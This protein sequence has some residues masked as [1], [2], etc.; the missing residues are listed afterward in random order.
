MKLE[1]YN[2][3]RE[4]KLTANTAESSTWNVE[5]MAENALSVS[6]TQ[7]S[8]VALEVGDYVML[9]GIKFSINKEYKPKQVSTLEYNYNVKFYGPEHDAERVLFLNLTDGQYVSEFILDGSPI[10]HLQRWVENM[11]RIYGKTVWSIG[12]VVVSAYKTI[13]YNN[14]NCWDALA[15]MAETFETEWWADGFVINLCR[16]ERGVRVPLGYMEGMTSLNQAENSSTVKFFTRLIPLGSTRNIDRQRYG[17][18]RLQLPNRE[19]YV[20]RNMH[21]GLFEA[22][23]SAA[24]ADIYPRYRGTV[25]SVRQEEKVGEDEKHFTVYYF[26]DNGMDFDPSQYGIDGQVKHITFQTGDLAGRDFEAN[27]YA[28]A[29][30]WEI[31]NTYPS[32]QY[33]VPGGN[34]IPRPG[35]EYIPW[36]FS[37]PTEYIRRAEKE[38]KA[39]VDDYLAKYSNDI[40]KYGGDTDAI[41]IEK[42]SVPLQLGQSVRLLSPK[43]FGAEGGRDSRMTKVVRKLDNL[44]SASIECTNQV[45][46]G[47]KKSVDSSLDQ[48]KYVVAQQQEESALDIMKSWDSR[49]FT[50]YRVLSALR[51]LNEIAL[52]ALSRL[53]NDEAAGLIT[54]LKGV[55]IGNKGRGIT[56]GINGSV[57]AVMDEIKKILSIVS[58]S[59]VSG[60][61]GSGFILKE[62]AETGDSY[63]EIDHLLVRKLAYF[64]EI[65]IKRLSYVGG[66]IILTP[67]SMKCIRVEDQGASY[68]C[69][70]EQSDDEKT[71][72]QEFQVGDQARAQTFNIKEGTSHGAS[73]NYYWRLV[74]GV[75]DDYIDLSKDDCDAKSSIPIAGDHIVQLGNRTDATRQ[76]AIILSTVGDDAPSIKQYKGINSYS[77]K[78]KEV[79]IISQALNMFQG[80]FISSSTGKSVDDMISNLQADMDLVREQTDREY[81]LWFFDYAP[82]LEN[83]PASD[84]VTDELKIMHEQ[85]MFY[86]RITGLAYRFEQVGNIWVWS[87]ITDQFTLAALEK[88]AKA[89][90]TADGKRR[91][92]VEQPR[93][94]QVYDVGDLWVNATYGLIYKN[95]QLVCKTA[96][97]AGEVFDIEHWRPASNITTAYIE[98]LG[99]QIILGVTNDTDKKIEA[100]KELAQ[101]GIKTATDIA[102]DAVRRIGDLSVDLSTLSGRMN[103]AD[104]TIVEHTTAIQATQ[105]SIA[106]LAQGKE[107]DE[108]GNITNISTSGLVTTA[109]FNSLFSERVEFDENGQIVNVKSSGI[110]TTADFS[111]MFSERADD[112][113]EGY[114]KRSYMATFITELP[115]GSF[116][117]NAIVDADL[118]RFNG[119]I[120][121]NDTFMVDKEGNLTLN[122]ITANNGVFKGEVIADNGTI[123]GFNITADSIGSET[124]GNSLRLKAKGIEFEEEKKYIGIGDTLPG[125]FGASDKVAAVFKT[126]IDEFDYQDVGAATVNISSLGGLGSCAL[127]IKTDSNH[128]IAIN[129]EGMINTN[130]RKRFGSEYGD[131]GITRGL[132]FQHVWD[133]SIGRF[134]LGD[135]FFVDGILTRIQWRSK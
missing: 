99:D 48:L 24:F 4:L 83:L 135:L 89:Q 132:C 129:Y 13:D 116:Q 54:F 106:L 46:K 109:Y 11:N 51:T 68:R 40:A 127:S 37:L 60:D 25:S 29:G 33:Q 97:A 62:D 59:F 3:N 126:K 85:D 42:H 35:D 58:P 30:E 45:G 105:E 18:P 52:R 22:V 91:V 125:I 74:V 104:D 9:D 1:I 32:D 38:F 134:R 120:V 21:Y 2:Q 34:L 66:E 92:F 79:T 123:G 19:V 49:E 15:M 84:W 101:E 124:A 73:N 100:L 77:M 20:E 41:Y 78:G 31:L 133:D 64:V 119:N 107:K 95:D 121:A 12:D 96:K 86:N 110:V 55:M 43:Y 7:P 23:E 102:G 65:V 98:N 26:K 88:A 14:I 36:N 112:T 50:D 70:F 81:T 27:Y 53:N 117:S 76:N 17:Y 56:V 10:Q 128:G 72:K 90:D 130:G 71:I 118:I 8:F 61:L 67:A 82:T 63:L 44:C 47:W 28:E 94:E 75:G 93:D 108:E 114:V 5:L 80:N 57:T 131:Y 103:T 111:Q 115:D 113:K 39:A 16:C 122:N 6:F 87:S 69:F